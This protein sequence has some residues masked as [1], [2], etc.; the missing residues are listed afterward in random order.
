MIGSDSG[1]VAHTTADNTVFSVDIGGAEF[2]NP[3]GDD[4]PEVTTNQG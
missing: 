2:S 1:A 3:G 4:Q